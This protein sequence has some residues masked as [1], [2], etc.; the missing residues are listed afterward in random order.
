MAY[1]AAGPDA[2]TDYIDESACSLFGEVV[3]YGGSSGFKG[4]EPAK[5]VT[6]PISKSIK[7]N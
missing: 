3:E 4:G 5:F 7:H 2:D 1:V 6:R